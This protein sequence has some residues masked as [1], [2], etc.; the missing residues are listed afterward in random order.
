MNAKIRN[1]FIVLFLLLAILFIMRVR[2]QV[3]YTKPETTQVEMIAKSMKSVV[4]VYH[5]FYDIP[6]SGFYIGNGIIVTAGHVAKE[7][8][9]KVV[10]E[11]G[12]ECP[13]LK[14]INYSDYDCGFLIIEDVNQPALKFDFKKSKRGEVVFTLGNP[15]N[16]TFVSTKG[17]ITGRT[18]SN[19]FF[20]DIE[21]LLAD[22]VSHPGNSGSVLLDEDGEIRGIH[23]GGRMTRCGAALHGYEVSIPVEY[24]LYALDQAGLEIE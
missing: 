19:G 9:K 21:L 5:S 8:I 22:A 20:G 18:D 23:V 17:I 1:A 12:V 14:R 11:N 13:V 6:A 10:F 2:I 3:R 15:R 24:I 7:D 16:V 4:A